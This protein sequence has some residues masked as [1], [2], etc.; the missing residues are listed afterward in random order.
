MQM[1]WI[2]LLLAQIAL[3]VFLFYWVQAL[4]DVSADTLS[5]LQ[6]V[7]DGVHEGSWA[8]TR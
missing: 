2:V 6:G 8:R 3:A 5:N 4:D 1:F 7:G